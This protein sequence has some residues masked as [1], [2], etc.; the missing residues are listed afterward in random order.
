MS[1][2]RSYDNNALVHRRAGPLSPDVRPGWTDAVRRFVPMTM[3]RFLDYKRRRWERDAGLRLDHLLLSPSA[4]ARLRT[5][6]VDR[7]VRGEEGASDHAPAWI[8]LGEAAGRQTEGPIPT[9]ALDGQGVWLR[10]KQS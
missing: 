6:G 3:Y 9:V 10:S 5:A 4:A 1:Q 7:A 2:T 8:T